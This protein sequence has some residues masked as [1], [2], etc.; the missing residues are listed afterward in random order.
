VLDE[1][2]GL[3]LLEGAIK[4]GPQA[5]AQ[6]IAE[7]DDAVAVAIGE[8]VDVAALHR[9][10][11]LRERRQKPEDQAGHDGG[12]SGREREPRRAA[13]GNPSEHGH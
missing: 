8:R 13:V 9:R 1:F 10:S 2:E 7:H 4:A 12:R 11:A 3:V 6:R 5:L